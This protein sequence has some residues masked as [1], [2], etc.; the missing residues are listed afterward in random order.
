[1]EH[2][3]MGVLSRLMKTRLDNGSA[4]HSMSTLFVGVIRWTCL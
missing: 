1:M 4:H 3:Q 2:P